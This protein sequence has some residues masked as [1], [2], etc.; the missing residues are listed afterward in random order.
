MHHLDLVEQGGSE[1]YLVL[2]AVDAV[3]Q[4]L[5]ARVA[6]R[7]AHCILEDR[8]D[9]SLYGRHRARDGVCGLPS[10]FSASRCAVSTC[11]P[12]DSSP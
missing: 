3:V 8:L 12:S 9:S 11:P 6:R 5:D 7:G 1:S 2:L 4:V 10:S